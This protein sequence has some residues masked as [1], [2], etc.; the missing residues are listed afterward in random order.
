MTA[1]LHIIELSDALDVEPLEQKGKYKHSFRINTTNRKYT[2]YVKTAEERAVWMCKLNYLIKA[3]PEPSV[4]CKLMWL[5][6][7]TSLNSVHFYRRQLP[8]ASLAL[9][10]C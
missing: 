4:I 10:T 5:A 3:I 7:K 6:N 8:S 1:P 9:C 2:F